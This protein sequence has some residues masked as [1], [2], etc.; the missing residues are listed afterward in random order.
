MKIKYDNR[1]LNWNE[2]KLE[3]ILMSRERILSQFLKKN[4]S[5]LCWFHSYQ[6]KDIDFLESTIDQ[7]YMQE[8]ELTSEEKEWSENLE[9][10]YQDFS[11]FDWELYNSL[12]HHE[13]NEFEKETAFRWAKKLRKLTLSYQSNYIVNPNFKNF[14]D[15]LEYILTISKTEYETSKFGVRRPKGIFK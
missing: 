5:N 9:K 6:K 10:F 13:K 14:N 12:N 8:E 11:S 4:K 7:I 15:P 3:V 2:L 1:E